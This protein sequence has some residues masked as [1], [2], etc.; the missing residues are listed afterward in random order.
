[1]TCCTL[2]CRRLRDL[3]HASTVLL[4]DKIFGMDNRMRRIPSSIFLI[5]VVIVG[6]SGSSQRGIADKRSDFR[7][8]LSMTDDPSSH[9][10]REVEP[11]FQTADRARIMA[12]IERACSV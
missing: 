2:S 9:G 12:A 7:R 11:Y 5:F 8:F 3:L 6:C 1:M 10:L 4:L